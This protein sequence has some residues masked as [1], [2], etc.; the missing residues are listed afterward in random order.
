MMGSPACA[1]PTT[2]TARSRS[3]TPAPACTGPTSSPTEIAGIVSLYWAA[4]VSEGRNQVLVQRVGLAEDIRLID[5][6]RPVVRCDVLDPTETDVSA[7]F[8]VAMIAFVTSSAIF[9]F[10]CA[11]R[12]RS[13]FTITC[14]MDS[15]PGQISCR[16]GRNRISLMST[17]FG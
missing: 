6:L 2:S 5:L 15:S 13:S 12:P 8:A 11:E 7:Q 17:S 3:V 16:V 9:A 14:G 4:L 1:E 10:C